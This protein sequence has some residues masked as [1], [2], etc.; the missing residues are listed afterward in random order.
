MGPNGPMDRPIKHRLKPLK[1]W[2]KINLPFLKLACTFSHLFL[3]QNQKSSLT[4][5]LLWSVLVSDFSSLA[6]RPLL[7]PGPSAWRCPW[8]LHSPYLMYISLLLLILPTCSSFPGPLASLNWPV[9][10]PTCLFH[11]QMAFL[12]CHNTL[13]RVKRIHTYH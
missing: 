9:K 2:A 8:F 6:Y 11:F 12:V 4:R 5:Y 13:V 7:S 3:F 10:S 1:L